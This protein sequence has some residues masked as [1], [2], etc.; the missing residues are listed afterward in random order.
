[1]S[2][3]QWET[4]ESV[5]GDLQAELLRGLLEAQGITVLLS[6]EGAGRALG[7]SVGT[8]GEVQILVPSDQKSQ[9]ELILQ[10]YYAGDFI[11]EDQGDK[12]SEEYPDDSSPDETG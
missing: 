10:E 8:L 3:Q 7:L 11:A 6:R 5:S 2:E 4:V 9:A 1:M 12:G